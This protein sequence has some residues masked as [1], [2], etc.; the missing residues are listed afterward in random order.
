MSWGIE[1][2][3]RQAEE[4]EGNYEWLEA[5]ESYKNALS[6][7]PQDEFLKVGDVYEHMSYAFYR[8]AMQSR[9]SS[10]FMSR[11]SQAVVSCEQARASYAKLTATTRV[12]LILRCNATVALV[13]YWLE[14]SALERKNMRMSVGN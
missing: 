4:K 6:L 2:L 11:I 5:V 12:P 3:L 9:S 13:H 14:S 1:H 7:L 8:A 10:E